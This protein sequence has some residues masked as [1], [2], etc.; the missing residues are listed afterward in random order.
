ME[1]GWRPSVRRRPCPALSAIGVRW[2]YS[3]V[4]AGHGETVTSV[5][6]PAIRIEGLGFDFDGPGGRLAVLD[7][8][9]LAVADRE[10]VAI[11]GPNGSGKSTL[12]RLVAGLLTPTNGTIETQGAIGLVFQEPRLLPWRSAV[13][14]AAYPLE[15]AGVPAVDRRERGLELL[16]RVG[17]EGAAEARPHQLSG[18]MRQRVAIAR[19]LARDPAILLLD[20]PFS[21]LD[22]LTRER[23]DVEL[24]RLWARTGTTILLVTH[25]VREA[26]FL[27]DRVV[28][29]TERP[30]R[31][32]GEVRSPLARPRGIVDLDD[33]ALSAA[34]REVRRL[35]GWPAIT[36]DTRAEIAS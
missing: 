31:I 5:Q 6:P 10:V 23:F 8:I 7:S 32:A 3:G 17:V 34:A 29:L 20:E 14:N 12:L 16:K 1:E 18:G 4:R 26:L 27:A 21:A 35:L 19:A 24:L 11:V 13:D 33:P 36:D 9:D 30:A 22:A 28:V 2:R 15:L 25:D